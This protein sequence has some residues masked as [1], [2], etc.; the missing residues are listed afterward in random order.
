MGSANPA[1]IQSDRCLQAGFLLPVIHM[2][3]KRT[4]QKFKIFNFQYFLLLILGKKGACYVTQ[5]WNSCAACGISIGSKRDI[6][7]QLSHGSNRHYIWC[8]GIIYM[9]TRHPFL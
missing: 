6:S 8:W 5:P 2:Y 3:V 9:A 7:W 4:A 1:M